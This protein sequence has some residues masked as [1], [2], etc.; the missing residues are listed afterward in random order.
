MTELFFVLFCF[1]LENQT[2]L[3]INW[4]EKRLMPTKKKKPDRT[5]IQEKFMGILNVTLHMFRWADQ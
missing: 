2:L 3:K 4:T 1:F 5:Q